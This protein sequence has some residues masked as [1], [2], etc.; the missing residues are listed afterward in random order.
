MKYRLS[1][2]I[3]LVVV[4]TLAFSANASDPEK[5]SANIDFED[6]AGEWLIDPQPYDFFLSTGVFIGDYPAIVIAP[7][8][9]FRAYL[10]GTTC[11]WFNQ[12][13]TSDFKN[14]ETEV[15]CVNTLLKRQSDFANGHAVLITEGAI[16]RSLTGE[17]YFVPNDNS[18][19]Q[20]RVVRKSNNAE[21]GKTEGAKL[22]LF[23]RLFSQPID[24]NRISIGLG[25]GNKSD[26]K[27]TFSKYPKEALSDTAS[28][29]PNLGVSSV[30][31]FRCI[32]DVYTHLPNKPAPFQ[33]EIDSLR[34]SV[35]EVALIEEAYSEAAMKKL[36]TTQPKQNKNSETLRNGFEKSATES[37]EEQELVTKNEN[38]IYGRLADTPA[39]KA[40]G[41]EKL[42]QYFGCPERDK[43]NKIP[44]EYPPG[45]PNLNN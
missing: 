4:L 3:F 21:W 1:C 8:G 25:G 39:A 34:K 41:E 26:L 43:P 7:N 9:E 17:R 20:S 38:A 44:V 14:N 27:F 36:K 31:Y 12:R 2:R 30:R 6:I 15:D 28:T 22:A 23:Q 24:S 33:R 45:F 19:F 13:L 32:L 11:N 18:A 16:R 35:R 29:I 37:V 40:A 10:V 42:G 5:P